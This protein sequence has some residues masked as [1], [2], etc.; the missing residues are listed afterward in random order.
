MG[1]VFAID[2]GI[3]VQLPDD[4]ESDYEF[5][6][7]LYSELGVEERDEDDELLTYEVREALIKRFPLLEFEHSYISDWDCGSVLFIRSTTVTY[8]ETIGKINSDK[9]K[10]SSE[11]YQQLEEACDLLGI[12]FKPAPLVVGSYG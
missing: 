12:E 4:E 8:F 11:E 7:N 2:I 3:G 10:M 1:R 5:N 9:W 6:P